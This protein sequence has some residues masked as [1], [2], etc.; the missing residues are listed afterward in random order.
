M[1]P[2]NLLWIIVPVAL[3]AGV[4]WLSAQDGKNLPEG[5]KIGE[6]AAKLQARE[7]AVSQ[8][9][10]TLSQLEQRLNTLQATLTQEQEKNIAAEKAQQ[11]A[12]KKAI[13]SL[14]E[15]KTKIEAERVREITRVRDR[16]KAIE[17]ERDRELNRIKEE[18]DREMEKINQERSRLRNVTKVDEQ[19]VRTFEAMDPIQASLA[20]QELS[21]TNFDV[22][23]GLMASMA[24]KKAARL[25]D[26]LVPL[27]VKLSGDISER[28]GLREREPAKPNAAR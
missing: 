28:L 7:K 17:V 19:L 11:E 20:L 24:P 25:L 16:E 23:V 1:S 5:V 21:K 13:A 8:K 2:R 27:D 15:E 4:L 9:E 26:Q 10:A 12:H 18:Q 3:S 6:L 14:A 22:A